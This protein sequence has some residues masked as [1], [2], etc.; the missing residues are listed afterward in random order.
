VCSFEASSEKVCGSC[1]VDCH[2]S[3]S[4]EEVNR[5]F[6][7][8]ANG[9]KETYSQS[10]VDV[11]ASDARPVFVQQHQVCSS[12]IGQLTAQE[13]ALLLNLKSM[14]ATIDESTSR[15]IATYLELAKQGRSQGRQA[16]ATSRQ[17]CRVA[18]GSLLVIL[19]HRDGDNKG[20]IV[21]SGCFIERPRSI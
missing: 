7:H 18:L 8:F 1:T 10:E 9:I 15:Y 3:V 2:S 4:D 16:S 11:D 19:R 17:Q 21:P 5:I 13:S 6:C 14:A 20:L 12:L